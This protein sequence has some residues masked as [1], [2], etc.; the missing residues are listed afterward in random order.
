MRWTETELELVRELYP[1]LPTEDV[2]ALLGRKIGPVHQCAAKM[3]VFKS[4]EFFATQPSG[5]E[6]IATGNAHR[7]LPGLVPWNKGT[8][9]VMPKPAP[10]KGFQPGSMPVTWKPIGTERR[11]KDGHMLR[12]VSDTRVKQVDWQPLRNIVWRE[13]FGEIPPGKF[14]ICKDRN[15]DNLDPSNL[16]AV[17]RAGNMR[18]NSYH[19]RHPELAKLFQLKGAINRQV[20]RITRGQQN[21]QP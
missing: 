13:N 12:K 21:E 16:A 7:F 1:D 3:K 20:N 11:D 9:G 15:P 17:D 19:T 14:V 8:K 5:R 2:A 18:L 10:G 4:L 6:N